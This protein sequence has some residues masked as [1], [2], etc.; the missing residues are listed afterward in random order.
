MLVKENA[1]ANDNCR[2]GIEKNRFQ[3]GKRSQNPS[4]ILASRSHW[5]TT[6][7]HG[8]FM[9]WGED[10]RK[11]KLRWEV[12]VGGDDEAG[13]I[14]NNE[15]DK[16]ACFP[17]LNSAPFFLCCAKNDAWG[18]VCS[19]TAASVVVIPTHPFPDNKFARAWLPVSRRIKSISVLSK[20]RTSVSCLDV[21]MVPRNRRHFAH[22]SI[23]LWERE[24]AHQD[25]WHA[26]AYDR[27]SQHLML[28]VTI[29]LIDM[30]LIYN[31]MWCCCMQIDIS[32]YYRH[33]HN[34]VV[35][36]D[37]IETRKTSEYQMI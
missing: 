31:P 17:P 15:N 1:A 32:V 16:C 36:L 18:F 11:E 28:I 7:L 35:L 21:S 23:D 34:S 27:T 9:S 20:S 3:L 37:A 8:S 6:P 22:E 30:M 24:K 33:A 14:K 29:D 5:L 12:V 13:I 4:L 26:T 19:C 2:W 10:Q 25:A